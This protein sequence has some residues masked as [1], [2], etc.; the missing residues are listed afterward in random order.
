M[1]GK[2]FGSSRNNPTSDLKFKTGSVV[3][4]KFRSRGGRALSPTLGPISGRGTSSFLSTTKRWGF[5]DWLGHSGCCANAVTVATGGHVFWKP[6]QVEFIFC[7]VALFSIFSVAV[8]ACLR[9]CCGS[10]AA[11][12]RPLSG[13]EYC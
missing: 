9:S 11:R 4:V 2:S 3:G 6:V 1:S 12:R 5:E 8:C 10:C 7:L 13:T